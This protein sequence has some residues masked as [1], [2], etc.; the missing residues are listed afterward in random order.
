METTCFSESLVSTYKSTRRYNPEDQQQHLH[1]LENLKLQILT[2]LLI[3]LFIYIFG[4]VRLLIM[5]WRAIRWN[6]NDELWALDEN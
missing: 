3:C 6:D 4:F 1:R 2:Y 5:N